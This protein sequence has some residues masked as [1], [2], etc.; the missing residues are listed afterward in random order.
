M[1]WNI[2]VRV[3]KYFMVS[4]LSQSS[5]LQPVLQ[6][7]WWLVFI[8]QTVSACA[9][10]FILEL[11]PKIAAIWFPASEIATATSLGV[12]GNQL[13][14]ALGFLIPPKIIKGPRTAFIGSYKWINGKETNQTYQGK[15]YPNYEWTDTSKYNETVVENAILEVR[16]QINI[17]YW[18]FAAITAVLFILVFL[19][20]KDKPARPANRASIKR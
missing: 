13:G 17:L 9:Q 3:V 11:P 4:L 19:V 18:G 6:S 2:T 8:G 16:G 20:F 12:F 15:T 1:F 10:C 5:K 14:V 7:A